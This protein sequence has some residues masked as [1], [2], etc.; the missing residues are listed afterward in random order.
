MEQLDQLKAVLEKQ[1]FETLAID[2]LSDHWLR[3]L[4]R[5]L[6]VIK[7]AYL[8]Y[9]DGE[10]SYVHQPLFDRRQTFDFDGPMVTVEQDGHVLMTGT[11]EDFV[12]LLA[13][14]DMVY[15]PIYPLGTVV[16]LDVELFPDI[17]QEL[18]S[19][20]PGATV[21][22]TGRKLTLRDGFEDYVL[23]YTARLW[24]IGE[25]LGSAQIRVSNLM[26][27]HVIAL[28]YTDEHWESQA[29]Q[30]LQAAQAAHLQRSTAF[31][32]PAQALSYY[33][34]TKEAH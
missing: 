2:Q 24:P 25:S 18:F 9:R 23:D 10:A 21:M 7:E 15:A 27:D 16:A 34:L 5:N 12:T 14:V 29:V 32:S 3:Y 30:A 26:I 8:A 11:G 19:E 31:M 6:D 4:G 13:S 22:L 17:L 33:Q 1:T 20:E 28:G